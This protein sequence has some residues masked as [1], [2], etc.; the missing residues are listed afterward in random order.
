MSSFRFCWTDRPTS[1]KKLS[2]DGCTRRGDT[3]VHKHDGDQSESTLE[4]I[5]IE[6]KTI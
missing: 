2:V 1:H 3:Y 5:Q 4:K 6:V